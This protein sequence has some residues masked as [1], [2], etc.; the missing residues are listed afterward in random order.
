MKSTSSSVP[1][2]RTVDMVLE[3]Y[4]QVRKKDLAYV[5]KVAIG[6]GNE[7][8]LARVNELMDSVDVF[9]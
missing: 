5:H 7:E 1:T 2:K 6:T 3:Y 8:L 4:L 9:A